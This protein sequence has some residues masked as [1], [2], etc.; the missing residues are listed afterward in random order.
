ML[1]TPVAESATFSESVPYKT[2][3]TDEIQ[4]LPAATS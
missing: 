3:L 1:S 2:E 4:H